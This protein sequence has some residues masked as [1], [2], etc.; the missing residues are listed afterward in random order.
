MNVNV[1]IDSA[2][3]GATIED[4]DV[5][6]HATLQRIFPGYQLLR[7]DRTQL[8]GTPAVL[9]YTTWQ[10]RDG[11]ELYQLQLGIIVGTRL[12]VVTGTTLAASPRLKDEASL[13]QQILITF[14]P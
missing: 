12:Y 1:V 8:D 4:F 11:I 13:L 3:A 2:P 10:T 6:A 14:R 5:A 9:R 7:S